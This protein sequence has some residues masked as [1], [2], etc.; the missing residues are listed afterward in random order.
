MKNQIEKTKE[1]I[2][3]FI[4]ETATESG[5]NQIDELLNHD[6]NHDV[7]KFNNLIQLGNVLNASI[8][9]FE[10]FGST[11]FKEKTG[12]KL[13]KSEFFPLFFGIKKAWGYRL[14][15]AYKVEPATRS[16]YVEQ[17]KNPTIDGLIKFINPEKATPQK[18][19]ILIT[20]GER[21]LKKAK[22]SITSNLSIDDINALISELNTLKAKMQQS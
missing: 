18:S 19:E 11:Q 17:T 1:L 10:T 5:K 14:I 12:S 8:Y 9:W 6:S 7:N 13:N 3:A 2:N 22:D 21:K 16:N 4:L 15:Q 20:F